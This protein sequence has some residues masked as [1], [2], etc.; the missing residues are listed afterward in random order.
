M[1]SIIG[2]VFVICGMGL[3]G[4]VMFLAFERKIF[5]AMV[6]SLPSVIVFRAGIGFVR[7]GIA[8]K[9][10]RQINQQEFTQSPRNLLK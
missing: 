6:L 4:T 2:W 8:A 1:W 9:I 5:E 7:F 3:I 10:A